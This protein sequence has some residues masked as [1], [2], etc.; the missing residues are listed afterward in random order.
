[1]AQ[2]MTSFIGFDPSKRVVLNEEFTKENGQETWVTQGGLSFYRGNRLDEYWVY[3]PHGYRVIGAH[4]PKFMRSLLRPCDKGGQAAIIHN[5]LCS[6]RKVRVQKER[7]MVT[8]DVADAIFLEAMQVAGVPV[9][10][11][12]LLYIGARLYKTPPPPAPFETT[13]T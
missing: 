7:Q 10:K 8:R 3:V 5:Y 6:S 11:R 9:W 12:W 13:V 1:M 4:V 2:K